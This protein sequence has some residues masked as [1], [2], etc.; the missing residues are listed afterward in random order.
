MGRKEKHEDTGTEKKTRKHQDK[1]KWQEKKVL[2]INGLCAY[3]LKIVRS[4]DNSVIGLI[5]LNLMSS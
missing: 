4:M 5:N 1:E 3:G 2:D